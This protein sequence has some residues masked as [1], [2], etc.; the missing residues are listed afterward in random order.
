MKDQYTLYILKCND[1][2][3]YTGITNDLE[4]R[5][6]THS[7]KKGSKYVASRLPFELIYQ[8][9]LPSKS[10]ALKREHA[11]KAM[12]RQEKLDLIVSTHYLNFC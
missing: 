10:D 6:E 4:N 12:T 7:K 11:I 8:E 2:S 1:G 5:L 3:L 9:T